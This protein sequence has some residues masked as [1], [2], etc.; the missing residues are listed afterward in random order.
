M[1]Q[2]QIVSR[3]TQLVSCFKCLRLAQTIHPRRRDLVRCTRISSVS[4]Y[5]GKYS[6]PRESEIR[7]AIST[8]YSK[9]KAGAAAAASS[10]EGTE[11]VGDLGK[12]GRKSVLPPGVLDFIDAQVGAG[13]E[14]SAILKSVRL[15][16]GQ[17]IR[18]I[19]S[20]ESFVTDNQIKNR[21]NNLKSSKKSK[22]DV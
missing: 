1:K 18:A 21:C 17:Q 12:R 22:V 11:D 5:L 16:F 9:Q 2:I 19:G 14:T 13:E 15:E 7:T 3:E 20:G 8:L 6:L 4:T 10:A